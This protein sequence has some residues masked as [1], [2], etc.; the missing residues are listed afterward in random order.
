MGNKSILL[1]IIL[2]NFCCTVYAQHIS[3]FISINPT[4][5]TTNFQ[6]P[7]DSHT[8]QYIIEQGDSLTT[9]G[10]LPNNCDFAGYI[11]ISGS[12][13]NGYLGINSEDFPGGV[14]MLDINFNDDMKMWQIT[15]SEKVDFSGVSGTARNCS[16]TVTPWNTYITCEEEIRGDVAEPLDGYKD[17]GWCTEIDPVTRTIVDQDG[18]GNPDKIWSAGN[19]K[20]ENMVV[21]S[22]ERTIYEGADSNIGYLY[23]LVTDVPQ[24]LNSGKLYVYKNV[25][26]TTGEWILLNNS[27]IAE[28]N[29]T[30]SQ[31]AI[32]GARIFNGIE[33]V[34]INPLDGMVYFAVKNEDRIYR[35]QDSDP[36]TGTTIPSFEIYAGEMSYD[37]THEEGITSTPWGTGNDNLAF[38]DLG[39]L[40]V[41]QDG[42]NDYIWV[43]MAGHSQTNPK[44]KLFGICPKGAE[45]TGITFTPNFE[46]F[47][48]SIQHPNFDNNLSTQ[49]DAFNLERSFGNDVTLVVGRTETLGAVELPGTWSYF[50]AMKNGDH[51][52]LEWETEKEINASHFVVER[53]E[54]SINWVVAGTVSAQGNPTSFQQYFYKDH[55]LGIGLY[56]YRIKMMDFSTNFSLSD[57]KTVNH[58]NLSTDNVLIKPNPFTYDITMRFPAD[59]TEIASVWIMDVLGRKVSTYRIQNPSLQFIYLDLNHLESGIYFIKIKGG[60]FESV[61]KIM[62][63]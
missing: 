24:D 26:E 40:W 55:N 21:H 53:S 25:T 12:S 33:D 4:A 41:F 2:F 37:I 60:N 16:G 20:H 28:R 49:A 62:K 5:K 59:F 15:A 39:N 31:S 27:T 32:V 47:F 8:F 6:Y 11:P 63:K 29:S 30:L 13:T 54:D 9:G 42:S 18:D 44:V 58:D 17:W 57:V 1:I 48:M 52:L 36:I 61:Q 45:P 22:N 19:F 23:K 3:D 10:T 14:T 51:A 35:F 38:D 56:F 46:H 7:S 50:T 34:E 43:V